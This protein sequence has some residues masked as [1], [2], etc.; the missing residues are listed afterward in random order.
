MLFPASAAQWLLPFVVPIVFYVAW[1]DMSAMRIP[2]K[3]VMLLIGVYALI[4]PL[5]LPVQ[6]YLWGWLH[7]PII[8]ILGFVLHAAG[9]VG[10]GDAK[11]AAAMAPF[12]LASDAA[13]YCYL[14]TSTIMAG[15]II[16]RLVRALPALRNIAPH[17]QSWTHRQFPMGLP[18]AGSLLFYLLLAMHH[19]A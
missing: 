13:L 9:M 6:T 3:T 1:S 16:H 14:L 17:W 2:N 11:F 12:I 19:G 7:L 5:A 10:G 8:L 4:G 15:L 18:L